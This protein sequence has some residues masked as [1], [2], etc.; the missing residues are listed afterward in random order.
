MT[1]VEIFVLFGGGYIC[2]LS[3]GSGFVFQGLRK[4]YADSWSP[5]KEAVWI[6]LAMPNILVCALMSVFLIGI[7]VVGGQPDRPDYWARF[8]W[9]AGG[10]FVGGSF[11]M[12][13]AHLIN[14]GARA[15][16]RSSE[17]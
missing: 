16:R 17:A 2:G 7:L 12:L 5:K 3:C 6:A 14:V 11:V 1:L 9:Y 4:L 10:L 8:C 15:Y 13:A